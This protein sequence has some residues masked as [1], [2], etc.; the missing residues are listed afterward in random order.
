MNLVA[1]LSPR[2]GGYDGKPAGERVVGSGA[3]RVELYRIRATD[4][5]DKHV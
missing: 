2:T 1:S 4:G 3:M 5:G